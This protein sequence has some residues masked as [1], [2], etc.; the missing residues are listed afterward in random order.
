MQMNYMYDMHT[1]GKNLPKHADIGKSK[2]AGVSTL[3]TIILDLVL[4]FKILD[5]VGKVLD[6]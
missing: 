4:D 1:Q 3:I 6:F 2:E 5:L